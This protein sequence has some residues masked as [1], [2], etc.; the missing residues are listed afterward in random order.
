[1]QK[2]YL[3]RIEK[4]RKILR[5]FLISIPIAAVVGAVILKIIGNGIFVLPQC[6]IYRRTHL[7]C[8]GC[9]NTRAVYSLLQGEIL[10][11]L[12]YNPTIVGTAL[13]F[14]LYY[15]EM[16]F[17]YFGKDIK[18]MPVSL[19]FWIPVIV[20]WLI[21]LLSRNFIPYFYNFLAVNQYG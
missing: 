4:K 8:P 9:G 20:I 19:K 16:L 15:T 14:M 17:E 7:F 21:F 1:M 18:L 6:D 12:R 11:S 3:S 5:F 10:T 13:I 2:A